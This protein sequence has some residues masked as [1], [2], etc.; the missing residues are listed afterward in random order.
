MAKRSL[1]KRE[2]DLILALEWEKKGCVG[3]KEIAKRLHC[4]P[5]YARKF[6]HTLCKKGWLEPIVRGQYQT[7]TADR[8]PQGVPEMNPYLVA[9]FLHRPY[10]FAYRFACIHHRLLTQIPSVIHVAVTR[11]KQP[12]EIKNVRFEFVIISKK[13]FFGFEE[14][15]SLGEK[16]NV[17][18]LER[19]VLDTLDRPDLVGG[20]EA[21][22]QA[23][24]QAG[25]KLNRLKLL[26]HLQRINDSAL[27]RRFGYL[28]K[29]FRIDLGR[30]LDAY[31]KGQICKNPAYLGTPNR[32][33]N[34]G[35]RDLQWNLIVNVPQKELL[36][37]I[38]IV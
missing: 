24:F 34:Q 10:F 12:I 25:K 15:T 8:G 28:A 9:R 20:I 37:E 6:A 23:V 5:G 13:R 36:G 19:T 38:K 3:L 18:N 1:S 7:I 14:S 2:S 27:A 17:S 11:Q 30:D 29:L 31:L 22:A 32:W 35:E 26:D 4:S 33:G 16:I 21:A